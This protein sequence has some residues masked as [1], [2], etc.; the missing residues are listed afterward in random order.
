MLEATIGRQP[1]QSRRIIDGGLDSLRAQVLCQRVAPAMPDRVEMIDMGA[2][3][4]D[5]R[6]LDVLDLLQRRVI[7]SSRVLTSPGPIR[8]M[9]KL[10]RQDCGLHAVETAI[11]ALDLVL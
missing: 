10:C 7:K 2:P 11:D 4:R 6:H 9:W 5:L 8:Q 3:G 1:R